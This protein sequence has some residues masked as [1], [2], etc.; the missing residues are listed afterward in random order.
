METATGPPAIA[1]LT[2]AG[3]LPSPPAPTVVL[4]LACAAGGVAARFFERAAIGD[5]DEF[6]CSDIVENMVKTAEARIEKN[7]WRAQAKIIDA[8]VHFFLLSDNAGL[9]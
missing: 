6:V 3:L 4:D 5:G 9:Y 1:M 2:Q 8:H 7:G